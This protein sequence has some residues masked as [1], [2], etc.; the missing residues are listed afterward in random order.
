[1][2]CGPIS[3]HIEG[4]AVPGNNGGG[5]DTTDINL[6]TGLTANGTN[7]IGITTTSAAQCTT[8]T[9]MFTNTTSSSITLNNVLIPVNPNI[10]ITGPSPFPVTLVPGETF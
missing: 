7:V 6:G 3:F 10:T 4:V 9:V 2:N 1:M 8:D 5:P